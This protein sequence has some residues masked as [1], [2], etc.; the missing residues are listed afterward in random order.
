MNSLTLDS[1]S[2]W[3]YSTNLF[4]SAFRIREFPHVWDD[5]R[6]FLPPWRKYLKFPKTP[7]MALVVLSLYIKVSELCLRSAKL[8]REGEGD[9]QSNQRLR[10]IVSVVYKASIGRTG[11]TKTIISNI[12]I[13]SHKS[14]RPLSCDS[15]R[16]ALRW[17]SRVI[18]RKI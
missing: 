18:P 2:L 3:V 13:F 4:L 5:R 14:Y 7:R 15:F 10:R 1:C 9:L 17:V 8:L 16:S 6:A 11:E 12:V